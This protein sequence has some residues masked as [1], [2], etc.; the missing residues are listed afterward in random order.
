MKIAVMAAGG[1]GSYYGALLAN[2]ELEVTFIARGAPLKAIRENDLVVK[3]VHGDM[4]IRPVRA[5]DNPVSVGLPCAGAYC[6][7]IPCDGYQGGKKASAR[8]SAQNG[9]TLD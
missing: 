7:S 3:S 4:T 1:L 5:T 9:A 2:F 6:L 8:M